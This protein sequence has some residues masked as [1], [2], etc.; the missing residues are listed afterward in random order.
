M[1]RLVSGLLVF[2]ML[3]ALAACGTGG[4]PTP[5][6][7]T[8]A[9]PT[10]QAT[11]TPTPAP[12]GNDEEEAAGLPDGVPFEGR[13]AIVTNT[14]DQNEE[15]FRSAEALQ[16]RFGSDRVIHRTW[17]VMFAQEGEMM[18]TILQE[19]ASDPEVRAIIIN[20][21]VI[22][23]N[24]AV[25][26]V[27]EMR[28]NDV[29]IVMANPAENTNDVAARGN[30]LLDI[31]QPR[32]GVAYVEQAQRMGAETILHY[33]FPRHMS[34]PLLAM[35]RDIMAE[36]AAQLGINFIEL[37]APDPMGDGG[38]PATQ[39]HMTQDIPRQVEI[40]GVNTAIFGT[41]CGMQIPLIAQVVETGALYPMPCDPSPYHGFPAALGIAS[42]IPSG[43]FNDAGEEIML[44]R[45]MAE[46]IEATRAYLHARGMA[47]RLAT[48]PVPAS[49][50]WTT[51][52][53][54]Y[55]ILWMNGEVSQE[56]GVIDLDALQRL[57]E[58]YI[59]ENAGEAI[60]VYFETL[61]IDGQHFPHYVLGLV[62]FLVY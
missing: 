6:A 16:L 36:T 12:T 7:S 30:L 39:M 4:T 25:D 57:A 33:S 46:V 56:P 32:V 55:A 22:N 37:T 59:L 40:H 49:M 27:R 3:F 61:T 11:P 8:P 21:S 48:W 35:R 41:N 50:M 42:H 19:I 15:E 45:S 20:Q 23:T 34:M 51:I 31:N 44:L 53:A 43:E 62:D 5:V 29:F 54:E 9:P 38:M 13:I 2:I 52:G 47:G 28:G 24:A 10:Q 58:A 17:P 1:K 60:P 14:V 18:I 26:R